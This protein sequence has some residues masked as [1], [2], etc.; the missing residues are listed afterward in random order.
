MKKQEFLSIVRKQIRFV[1]DRDK[2]EDELKQHLAD[3][4]EDLIEEGFSWQDAERIAVEQ[5]GNPKEVGQL[6]N[7]EHNPILGYLWAISRVALCIFVCRIAISIGMIT[8]SLITTMKPYIPKYSVESYAVNLEMEL[9]THHVKLD[10]ICRNESGQYF[11]TFRAWPKLEYSRAGWRSDFFTIE[12]KKGVIL[13]GATQTMNSFACYGTKDFEWPEDSVLYL[14]GRDG[15]VIEMNL[16]EYC[17]EK[18]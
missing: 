5:M 2:I 9:P 17:D 6:L 14:V 4:I 16:E 15:E 10:N 3:S 1:F 18:R 12:D 8:F 11:L 13:G 7:R